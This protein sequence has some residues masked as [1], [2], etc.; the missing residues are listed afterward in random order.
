MSASPSTDST[1]F[2]TR[3]HELRSAE[4]QR[5]PRDARTV[6]HGGAAG[7]WYFHWFEDNYPGVVQ[8]HIGVEAFLERPTDLPRNVEWLQR[9]LGD[10]GPV[11]TGSVDLVFG[12]QVIEH[13][14]ADDV[15]D[16]LIESH[17]VL[18]PGGIIALDS[19]NRR[20]TEAIGWRHPQHTVEFSVDEIVLLI[21]LAGFE[22]EELRGVLLSY[23][24]ARHAFL[25]LED[26][27]MPWE[28]R[29]RLAADRPEDGFVWWLVAR[30]ADVE[31]NKER[32]R[33]LTHELADAFRARRMQQLSSP[34]PVQRAT[35]RVPFVSS[36]PDYA[37]P[38]LH[39]PDFPLDAGNWRASFALRL[40]DTYAET[41]LPV[42]WVEV[43]SD[44][45]TV[46]HT[47]REVLARDLDLGGAWTTISV[48][49]SLAEMVMGI[50][51]AAFTHGHALVGA[52]MV[53]DLRRPADVATATAN[54]RASAGRPT[55]IAEPRTV[56]II[57]MLNRR[58]VTKA[59]AAMDWRSGPTHP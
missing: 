26:K 57:A 42:A 53:V 3:L 17:R 59:K 5:L 44:S 38:L 33:E 41:G 22:L 34:L 39:G 24:R 16:F 14:W 21:A 56:E 7:G 52:Q 6:L 11:P 1:D 37:G 27:R 30:R 50:E 4:L 55:H 43:A 9:T 15:A 49:F 31:P 45:G 2:S 12:G 8:R 54:E 46:E 58:A 29:S 19:P 20:V 51:L 35:G 13:L 40:A 10:M 25:A 47:R 48:D 23:D 32:L 18:Q 28:E 36:P